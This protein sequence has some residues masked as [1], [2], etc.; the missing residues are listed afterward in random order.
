[1]KGS[2]YWWN[3]LS[4]VASDITVTWERVLACMPEASQVEELENPTDEDSPKRAKVTMPFFTD[5]EEA[6]GGMANARWIPIVVEMLPG[7]PCLVIGTQSETALPLDTVDDVYRVMNQLNAEYK[8]STLS[9][10]KGAVSLDFLARS[11]L[12]YPDGYED[13]QLKEVMLRAMLDTCRGAHLLEQV[14]PEHRKYPS[15]K[16]EWKVRF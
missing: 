12:Y 8:R 7:A 4:P 3:N 10:K 9:C 11:Y 16:L 14:F 1:M 6:A 2:P 13:E 15:G 5:P